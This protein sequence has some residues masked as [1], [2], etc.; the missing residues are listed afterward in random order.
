MSD[1]RDIESITFIVIEIVAKA[2]NR[3]KFSITINSS[4]KDLGIKMNHDGVR[5]VDILSECQSR[6]RVNIP[7][8]KVKEFKTIQDVVNFIRDKNKSK[9]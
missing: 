9:K 1:V 8:Q 5:I 3:D 6:F 2:L 4:F 7:N